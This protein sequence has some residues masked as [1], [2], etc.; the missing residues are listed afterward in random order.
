MRPLKL[1]AVGILVVALDLN[2]GNID[3]LFDP[4]GYALVVAGVHRLADRHAGFRLARAAALVGLVASLFTALLRRTETITTPDPTDWMDGG[5]TTS[6]TTRLVEPL[7]PTTIESASQA[8]FV[9]GV[10]TALMVLAGSPKVRE[11]AR[12]LRVA[13]PAVTLVATVLALVVGTLIGD[14]DITSDVVGLLGLLAVGLALL[15]LV[16][17]IWF[18]IVLLRASREPGLQD[19]RPA[20]MIRG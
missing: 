18:F 16:L 17:A 5:G 13:L 2:L 11:P 15:G 7:L 6:S 8:V 20:A 3:V 1:A 19:D 10:C 14:G 9:I 12:T 4:L